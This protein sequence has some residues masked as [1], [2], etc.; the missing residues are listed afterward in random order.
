MILDEN[1]LIVEKKK[2]KEDEQEGE[3]GR[4]TQKFFQFSNRVFLTGV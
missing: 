4:G 3:E 1:S 2:R